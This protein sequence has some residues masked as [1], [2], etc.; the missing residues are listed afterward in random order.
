MSGTSLDGLDVAFCRISLQNTIWSFEI[1]EAKTYEYSKNWKE[2]LIN[3]ENTTAQ[4]FAFIHN[5]YGKY[6][7]SFVNQ[8]I[9]EYKLIPDFIASHGHTIFHQ[10]ERNLTFQ[11]G[12]GAAIVAETG[13]DVVCDFR[14]LDIALGGQG[15][16]LVPVGDKYFFSEYDF[17]LN[18]GGFANISIKENDDIYAFDICPVNIVL[19]KFVSEL[20]FD[21]DENGSIAR[22]GICNSEILKILDSLN[23]YSKKHPKSLGKEWVIKNIFPVFE[24]SKLS[25]ED[26]LKIF[27]EHASNQIARII[28]SSQNKKVLITGG[29]AFNNFLIELIQSKTKNKLIIPDKKIIDFK[30]ALIFALLGVLRVRNEVNCLKSVT[31]AKFDNIGGTIYKGNLF[32]V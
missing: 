5:D 23:F 32:S 18:I 8:F 22:K 29:G 16:P 14:S 1:I 9:L 13:I 21:F 2:I 31:G 24:K 17:C 25:V 30:E 11:I 4:N 10:P 19:N 3:L 28:N 7:G 27:C 15:A 6:I 12:S 26:K 20:G